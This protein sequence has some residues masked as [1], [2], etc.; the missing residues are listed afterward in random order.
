M[1]CA[2]MYC[3]VQDDEMAELLLDHGADANL[4]SK[5]SRAGAPR[6]GWQ[7]PANRRR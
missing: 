4:G 2:V 7:T 1:R 3:A 6:G 5:V